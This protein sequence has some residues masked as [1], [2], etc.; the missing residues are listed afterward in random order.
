MSSHITCLQR[1]DTLYY[2]GTITY[3]YEY[4][5]ASYYCG[6]AIITS[7]QNNSI[8]T[9]LQ[10][11]TLGI[12]N[13][14]RNFAVN[15]CGFSTTMDIGYGNCSPYYFQTATSIQLCICS[16]NNC[17]DTYSLCQVSVNQVRSSPPPSIPV[18]QPTL[19]NIITCQD[20]YINY[21]AT[22]N[23]IPPMYLGCHFMIR[24][25]NPDFSRCSSCS[26]NHT[27]IC[28]V[29]YSPWQGSFQQVAMIEGDYEVLIYLVISAAAFSSNSSSGYYA[30]QTSRSIA[31]LWPLSSNEYG[32]L[33][34]CTT[35][36]CNT[37][38]ATCTQGMNIPSYLLSYNGST[39]PT[40]SVS[41]GTNSSSITISSGSTTAIT[42]RTGS[43]G[44]FSS[45]II[46]SLLSSA[47]T[48]IT[49]SI[50]VSTTSIGNS[51]VL[52]STV[53]RKF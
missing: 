40:S 26:P 31:T 25:G 21:S 53:T 37:D 13:I 34:L 43:T 50:T 24:L 8:Q 5:L 4:S 23:I 41:A 44:S 33:C 46:T 22:Q 30:Y 17:S 42:T 12:V 16:T 36:N 3:E 28:G 35:N 14:Y 51:S 45:S 9:V 47:T 52:S 20:A 2:N 10:R 32:G 7:L 18:L 39:S 49:A 48:P 1:T 15:R 11:F 19:S 38:F 29:Y 6:I 27:V